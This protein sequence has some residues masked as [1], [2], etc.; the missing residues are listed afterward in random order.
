MQH[1]LF[2]GPFS[3]SGTTPPSPLTAAHAEGLLDT[4]FHDAQRFR[5]GDEYRAFL[6]FVAAFHDYAPFNAA[7]VYAQMPGARYV[8]TPKRWKEQYGRDIVPGARPLVM[9]RPGGPV[10]FVF[11]V[12][13]TSGGMPLPDKVLRPFR[14]GGLSAWDADV[15]AIR[16]ARRDRVQVRKQATG[17]LLAG[18]IRQVQGSATDFDGGAPAYLV[19]LSDRFSASERMATLAHEL[20]HLYCGHLGNPF[21]HGHWP[22][23]TGLTITEKEFEAESVAY[24][25]CHRLGLE[26]ASASYLAGYLVNADEVPSISMDAVLR[27]SG[28]ILDMATRKVPPRPERGPKNGAK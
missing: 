12:S 9:L 22:D 18:S 4:L 21:G 11:D 20:A 19:L 1:T 8:L 6:H 3:G 10:M 16:N 25:V 14:V 17:S 7:L 27:A 26:P 15:Q 13:D 2:D 5:K 28:R 24:L 23:R